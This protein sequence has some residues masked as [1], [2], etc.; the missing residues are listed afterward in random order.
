[1]E[2]GRLS[3]ARYEMPVASRVLLGPAALSARAL[4]PGTTAG[5]EHRHSTSSAC[6][7][8]AEQTPS[9]G[10]YGGHNERGDE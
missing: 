2:G 10:G 6:A 7:T 4:R 5:Q 9:N 3:R 1:M 8:T